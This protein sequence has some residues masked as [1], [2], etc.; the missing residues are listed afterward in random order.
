MAAESFRTLDFTEAFLDSYVS[1][2]FSP[3]DR[4]LIKK[5]LR[6]LDDNE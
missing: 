5:A 6:L 3:A 4:K 2:D 1:R